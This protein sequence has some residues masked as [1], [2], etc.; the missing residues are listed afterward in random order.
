VDSWIYHLP[1]VDR[2]AEALGLEFG[3]RR[4][5]EDVFLVRLDD[6]GREMASGVHLAQPFL[7]SVPVLR[8]GVVEVFLGLPL[9]TDQRKPKDPIVTVLESVE[10][11]RNLDDSVALIGVGPEV[12]EE[13]RFLLARI[14][15]H[16]EGTVNR[17]TDRPW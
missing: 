4:R 8:D 11:E 6:D 12:L 13:V 16:R 1:C 17:V 3:E 15:D 2:S 9:D 7:E 5:D 10:S 14:H